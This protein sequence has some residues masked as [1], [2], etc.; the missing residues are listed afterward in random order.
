MSRHGDF[1]GSIMQWLTRWLG[2]VLALLCLQSP[3]MAMPSATPAPVVAHEAPLRMFNRTVF[4]FRGEFLG[5][6]PQIRA[7]RARMLLEVTLNQAG[8]LPVA[9]KSNPEGQLVTVGGALAFVVTAADIDPLNPQ[10]VEVL[11]A[12]AARRLSEVVA[13]TREARN[14]DA[15]LKAAGL[16]VL[17]T[18]IFVALLMVIARI[19]YRVSQRLLSLMSQASGKSAV[20]VASLMDR[21]MLVPLLRRLGNALR[22]LL[23]ALLTYEWLSF[24]LSRFPYT[25][26]WGRG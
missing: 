4:V 15:L 10:S 19:R 2:I 25:R 3:L 18:A 24:V 12:D 6:S 1:N 8:D 16:S 20:G 9:V 21:R 26:V 13:E 11:A 23:I 7:Q 17:A 14:I 5:A 22:W